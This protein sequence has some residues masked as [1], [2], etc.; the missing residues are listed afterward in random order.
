[1]KVENGDKQ[2]WEQKF[3]AANGKAQHTLK[4]PCF[5]L[6][7]F[8]AGGGGGWGVRGRGPSFSFFL[9]SQCVHIYIYNS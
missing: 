8:G 5:F 2:F 9:C 7:S 4:V 1:M 6:L 3:H